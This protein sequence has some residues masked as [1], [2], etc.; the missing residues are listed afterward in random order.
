[1]CS[2]SNQT[3]W[4]NASVLFIVIL[5][6]LPKNANICVIFTSGCVDCFVFLVCAFSFLF[7][8]FVT[9]FLIGYACLSRFFGYQFVPN[10]R[11]SDGIKNVIDIQLPHMFLALR[12]S[13]STSKILYVIN[14]TKSLYIYFYR[15]NYSI[16]PQNSQGSS[17]ELKV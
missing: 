1:M 14:K 5:N 11:F 8:C 9:L 13:I 4:V 7:L 6:Y 3:W 16:S 10:L 12:T 2:V 17:S 15:L